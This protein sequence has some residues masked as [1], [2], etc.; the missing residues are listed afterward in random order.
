MVIRNISQ[1][2]FLSYSVI[3]TKILQQQNFQVP[4]SQL[5]KTNKDGAISFK[6]NTIRKVVGYI[7]KFLCIQRLRYDRLSART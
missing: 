7:L 6:K 3:P 5:V 1:K 2:A 4:T